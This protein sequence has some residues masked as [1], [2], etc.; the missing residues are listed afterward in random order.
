LDSLPAIKERTPND[1]CPWRW[2]LWPNLKYLDA[3]NFRF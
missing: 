3:K 1:T 2:T